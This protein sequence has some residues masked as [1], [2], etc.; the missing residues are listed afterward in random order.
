MEVCEISNNW[1]KLQVS[2]N[3]QI[4]MIN[5]WNF[6]PKTF[7]DGKQ[8]IRESHYNY[9]KFF[10]Q[11]KYKYLSLLLRLLFSYWDSQCIQAC[12]WFKRR[13]NFWAIL[14]VA[15]SSICKTSLSHRHSCFVGRILKSQK[16]WLVLLVDFVCSW[17]LILA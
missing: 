11:Y 13:C 17:W 2:F 16:N 6:L 9:L 7:L 10:F 15:T 1:Q 8:R 12:S 14:V 3:F 4:W 5:W